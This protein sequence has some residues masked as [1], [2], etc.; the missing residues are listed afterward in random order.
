MASCWPGPPGGPPLP[1]PVP[2]G[3]QWVVFQGPPRWPPAPPPGGEPS[4]SGTLSKALFSSSS[5][6]WEENTVLPERR[7]LSTDDSRW[8]Q[9]R[10]RLS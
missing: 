4:G 3:P 1:A 8:L 7:V 9:N 6:S 5:S 10:P 2:S